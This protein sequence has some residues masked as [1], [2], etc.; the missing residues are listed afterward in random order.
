MDDPSPG[1][2]T[3]S[4]PEEQAEVGRCPYCGTTG[5]GFAESAAPSDYCGH[6]PALVRPLPTL[7]ARDAHIARPSGASKEAPCG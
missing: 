7:I 2:G 1:H 5:V 4:E 6:D 3:V